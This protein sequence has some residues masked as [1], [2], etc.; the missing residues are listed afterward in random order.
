MLAVNLYPAPRAVQ[1][2][3]GMTPSLETAWVEFELPGVLEVACL[4][5][6]LRWEQQW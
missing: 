6:L 5:G 3:C 4:P 2:M 1:V